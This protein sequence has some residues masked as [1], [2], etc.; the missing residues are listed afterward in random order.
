MFD[1]KIKGLDNLAA[2]LKKEAD[3]LVDSAEQEL[4]CP[5]CG[6]EFR[7]AIGVLKSNP[8]LDCPACSERFKVS[9]KEKP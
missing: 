5:K 4:A 3:K 7:K 1:F 8:M 6:H 2:S 9:Y